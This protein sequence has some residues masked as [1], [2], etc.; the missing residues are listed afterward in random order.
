MRKLLKKL[1]EL[2]LDLD[3]FFSLGLCGNIILQGKK[4]PETLAVIES[5][6]LEEHSFILSTYQKEHTK[7]TYYTEPGKE[8][9]NTDIFIALSERIDL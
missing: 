2:N 9:S 5:L 3:L 7:T 8:I 1:I 4:N 6:G